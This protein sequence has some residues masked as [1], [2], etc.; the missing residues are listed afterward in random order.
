MGDVDFM[1]RDQE[2]RDFARELRNNATPA[3]RH[4]WDFLRGKKL[5]VTPFKLSVPADG[6]RVLASI[7]LDGDHAAR[8]GGEPNTGRARVSAICSQVQALSR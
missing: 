3:E 5:G 2:Q 6:S 4:L 1:V 7:A 8:A